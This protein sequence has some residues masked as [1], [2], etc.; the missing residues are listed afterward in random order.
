MRDKIIITTT[1]SVEQTEIIKY[2]DLISTNVV[3]GTNIFSDIGASLSDFFG[4]FSETYQKKL[5]EIY[6]VAIDDLKTKASQIGANAVVG[7]KIDF[8]EISGKGKSMFMISALGTAVVVKFLNHENNIIEENILSVSKEQLYLEKT[9]RNII[10]KLQKYLPSQE[11]W[12]YLFNHPLN[13]VAELLLDLGIKAEIRYGDGTNELANNNTPRYFKLLDYDF[14]TNLLYSKLIEEPS[15][16]LNIIKAAEIFSPIK[17]IELL[18][19][20][21]IDL[22]ISCLLINKEY[23]SKDDLHLMQELVILLNNLPEKGRI[24]TVKGVLG[25]AREKYICPNGHTNEMVHNFC[26]LQSCQKNIKGL[27][28]LQISEIEN[29]KLEV[30]TLY[31]LFNNESQT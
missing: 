10:N 24:E 16:I 23:Y 1:N 28:K 27:T 14:A 7:L 13:D 11:D 20:G 5:N 15:F 31:S 6:N 26:E 8:D 17:L 22:A 21:E 30:D 4:G 9:K 3:I 19:M 18:K 29:F 12:A 25:K 2:V